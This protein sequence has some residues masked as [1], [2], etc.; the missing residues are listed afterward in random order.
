[1]LPRD[2]ISLQVTSSLF[3]F[4]LCKPTLFSCPM[5]NWP[6]HQDGRERVC[7]KEGK[8]SSSCRGQT[9]VLLMLPD[10]T[11]LLSVGDTCWCLLLSD[12]LSWVSS[13]SAAL[14]LVKGPSAV[15]EQV[16]VQTLCSPW[17]GWVCRIRRSLHRLSG[18]FNCSGTSQWFPGRFAQSYYSYSCFSGDWRALVSEFFYSLI[19]TRFPR[20]SAP[21]SSRIQRQFI[22]HIRTKSESAA[23]NQSEARCLT[24][25]WQGSVLWWCTRCGSVPW[26]RTLVT[27]VFWKLLSLSVYQVPRPQAVFMRHMGKNCKKKTL[28]TCGDCCRPACVSGEPSVLMLRWCQA[29][30]YINTL[31]IYIY[32]NIIYIYTYYTYIYIYIYIYTQLPTV[33]IADLK[34][35]VSPFSCGWNQ[36]EVVSHQQ[37]MKHCQCHYRVNCDHAAN[38]LAQV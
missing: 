7:N 24:G 33:L 17:R 12:I 23:D 25:Q 22:A 8:K 18:L 37:K 20:C 2:S 34:V 26:L 11:W 29:G 27:L 4:A 28:P 19:A 3:S 36:A 9:W 30:G 13:H 31:Y 35:L 6:L 5:W 16:T 10:E 15:T 38:W 1:M 32:I 21:E 14:Q